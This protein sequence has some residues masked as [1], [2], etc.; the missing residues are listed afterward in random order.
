MSSGFLED[1]F[2]AFEIFNNGFK[3][4]DGEE[5]SETYRKIMIIYTTEDGLAKIETT[6]EED[7]VWPSIAQMAEL[8]QSDKSTISRYVK[9]FFWMKLISIRLVDF[10][11]LAD[12]IG[13]CCDSRGI[14]DI[15]HRVR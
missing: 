13:V 10:V 15:R 4:K 8:F 5:Q 6:F 9:I 12:T 2:L 1:Y 3:A 7:M 14:P 11:L